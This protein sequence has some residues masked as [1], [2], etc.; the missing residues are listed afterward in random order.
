M[1]VNLSTLLPAKIGTSE[2]ATKYDVSSS[3]AAYDPAAYINAGTTTI[4]GGKITTGTITAG[5]IAA[6]SITAEKIASINIDGYNI[7]GVNI[8]GSLIEGSVIKSSW[9]DYTSTGDLTN[10]QYYTP[11]TVP[12]QY[13]AN[14]AHNNDGSLVVDSSGY[15]RLAGNFMNYAAFSIANPPPSYDSV[16]ST[17][18]GIG[19]YNLYT[20][21]IQKRCISARP[22]LSSS[23]QYLLIDA[24]SYS[25][26]GNTVNEI[27]VEFTYKSDNYR[28]SSSAVG[29]YVVK[30]N[31]VQTG[32]LIDGVLQLYFSGV[33]QPGYYPTFKISIEYEFIGSQMLTDYSGLQSSLFSNY[34]AYILTNNKTYSNILSTGCTLR[35]FVFSTS[36]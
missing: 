23:R 24:A 27:V 7:N 3:L 34:K 21:D 17:N 12:S 8:K 26:A 35:T 19:P 30:K 11:S 15:V 22:V 16:M 9:I 31:G 13:K 33:N 2:I 10:W 6:N 28:L 4:D 20:A 25:S 29:S 5:Q 18:D 1:S 32:T 36:N 14:F